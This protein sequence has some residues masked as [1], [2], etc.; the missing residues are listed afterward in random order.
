M[1]KS[2]KLVVIICTIAMIASIFMSI[3]ETKEYM[4]RSCWKPTEVYSMTNQKID[5]D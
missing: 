3:I 1:D 5:W 2:T 4:N